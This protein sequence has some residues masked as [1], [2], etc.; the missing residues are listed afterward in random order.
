[1]GFFFLVLLGACVAAVVGIANEISE[2]IG[3]ALLF[4]VIIIGLALLFAHLRNKDD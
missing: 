4:S 1:M 3:P 2:I